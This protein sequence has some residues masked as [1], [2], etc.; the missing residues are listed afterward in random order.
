MKS[1]GWMT[2][3]VRGLVDE[4]GGVRV[5]P[6]DV[7]RLDVEGEEAVEEDEKGEEEEVTDEEAV[8]VVDKE[9]NWRRWW[10]WRK[11]A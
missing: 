6:R 11:S 1:L 9:R 2:D 10:W 3:S 4:A 8:F 7:K 5:A